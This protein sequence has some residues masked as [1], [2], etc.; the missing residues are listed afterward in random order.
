MSNKVT[1][2]GNVVNSPSRNRTQNGSVTNFRLASTERRF[3]TG[4]QTWVDGSSFFVDVECW[5]ELGGNVSHS[6][7]KGDPVVVVGTIRTHSWDSEEGR[8]SRP[9]IKAEAVGPNL[10]RGT[11]EFRRPARAAAAAS[12]E[13]VPPSEE[14]APSTSDGL[15]EFLEGR[16][17]EVGDGTLGE[18]NPSDLEPAHV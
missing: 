10:A 5:G 2:T 1:F 18:V 7:S 6:V 17:Y 8:R 12:D 13:P 9:Q 16:D 4:S 3:D 14:E 11:A 15:S